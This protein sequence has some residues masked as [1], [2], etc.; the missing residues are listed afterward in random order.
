MCVLYIYIKERD[1]ITSN[2][3]GGHREREKKGERGSL[4]GP[5]GGMDGSRLIALRV[6]NLPPP[7]N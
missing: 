4:S 1:K 7:D 3:A 6:H 2:R 5:K